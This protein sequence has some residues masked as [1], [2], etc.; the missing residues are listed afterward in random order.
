MAKPL[1]DELCRIT[2]V[3]A[4]NIDNTHFKKDKSKAFDREVD[5][6]LINNRG[7]VY[8]IEVK[9]MGKG[10]P[11][12]DDAT[13]AR[14]SDIFVA[15]TLSEQNCHQLMDRGVQYLILKNNPSSL[16]DF[17]KILD[18]LDIPHN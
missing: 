9:L 14:E 2:D 8:R 12:S 1:L 4:K 17:I 3:P 5:Y 13:I 15:D 7:Q 6:K 16:D 11:E 10:N 18:Y